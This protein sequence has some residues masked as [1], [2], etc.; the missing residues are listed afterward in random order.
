MCK[1]VQS[2]RDFLNAGVGATM[3]DVERNV[4]FSCIGRWTGAGAPRSKPDGKPCNW[5]LGGL[6][7]LHKMEVELPDGMIVAT[8]APATAA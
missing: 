6:F 1:T 3:E 2:G 7:R 4:G 5:T 8:F